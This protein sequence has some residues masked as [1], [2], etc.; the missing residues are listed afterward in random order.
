MDRGREGVGGR[1]INCVK[2]V[3]IDGI[4]KILNKNN[5]LELV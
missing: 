4:L 3:F 1:G 2:V 5:N